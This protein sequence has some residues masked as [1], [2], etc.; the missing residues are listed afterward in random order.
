MTVA[1]ATAFV[2]KQQ[3]MWQ[4]VLDE[5]AKEQQAKEKK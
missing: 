2:H 4:P 3:G 5:I 1:E